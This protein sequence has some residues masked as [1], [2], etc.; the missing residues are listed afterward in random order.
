MLFRPGLLY[1]H[2]WDIRPLSELQRPPNGL[3]PQFESP[4]PLPNLTG[5]QLFLNL[6]AQE[7]NLELQYALPVPLLL[8][9]AA[10]D[11]HRLL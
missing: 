11:S 3:R 9:F 6:D 8:P 2:S 4:F 1:R 10:E 7:L 5:F